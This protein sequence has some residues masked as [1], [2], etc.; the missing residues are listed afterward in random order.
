M[1][2]AILYTELA[3]YTVSCL[4]AAS[5]RGIEIRVYRYPVHKEAPFALKLNPEI[6]VVERNQKSD[7]QIAN[8]LV[9]WKPDLVLVSGWRDKGYLK[10]GNVLAKK[11]P[12]ILG[13]DNPWHG[14]VRQWMAALY[15]RA[16]LKNTF[17]HCWVP[18]DKQVKYARKLGFAA[19]RIQTGAY[20]AD[21][22]LFNRQYE[23]NR[24]GKTHRFPKRFLYVG[25]YLSF[26]GTQELWEAFKEF[27]QRGNHAWELWCAGTGAEFE[28]RDQS[29]GIKHFGFLQPEELRKVIEQSGVFVLP[30]R[31]EP[32]G[33]VV[34]EFAAA[35]FPLVCSEAVGAADTF[36]REGENGFLFKTQS[37]ESLLKAMEK[38]AALSDEQLVLMGDKSHQLAQQITPD[39]WVQTLYRFL[40]N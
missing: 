13:L 22:S 23:E 39:T 28:Q 6:E 9:E 31:K 37:V 32:W 26:K 25:R 11:I 12:F 33:V 36:L 21:I 18:G 30:S 7:S 29:E 19:N 14:G 34:Q 27:R 20:S 10:C 3:A 2:F 24:S 38:I 40:D 16:F 8:E 15:S 17:T 35:G 4:N 1:R 5:N